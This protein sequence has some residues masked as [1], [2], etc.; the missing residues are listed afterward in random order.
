MTQ[1]NINLNDRFSNHKTINNKHKLFIEIFKSKKMKDMNLK[2]RYTFLL[3]ALIFVL[4][5]NIPVANAMD[6]GFDTDKLTE[7]KQSMFISNIDLCLIKSE[8]AKNSIVCF[9]VNENEMIAVG[10]KTSD[11]KIICIYSKY[12]TFQYGYTFNCD[13]SFGVEWD[14]DNLNIYFVR[15]S[16]VVSVTPDGEISGVLEVRNTIENN[17]YMNHYIHATK[18]TIGDNAYVIRNDI[19][20]FN[21]IATSYSQIIS[22]D[23]N[24]EENII[25]DVNSTQYFNT[26]AMFIFVIVFISVAV[27]IIIRQF[28]K[29]KRYNQ[30]QGL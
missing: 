11:K 12:G 29:L 14:K 18:R 22:I 4:I 26:V 23:S 20:I 15:S 9:D 25:Y 17:S 10:Q 21:L 27:A 8:P 1:L 28:V 24:G 13:G 3:F 6:T 16:V 5:T 7:E 30:Q 19:G 2:K